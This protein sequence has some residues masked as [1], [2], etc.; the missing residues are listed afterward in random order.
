[1]LIFV[2]PIICSIEVFTF[3]EN[4]FFFS[5]FAFAAPKICIRPMMFERV[6]G[7][8]SQVRCTVR[9]CQMD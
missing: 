8:A 5:N 2:I 9:I 3:K 1:M 4:E 7:Q 6:L